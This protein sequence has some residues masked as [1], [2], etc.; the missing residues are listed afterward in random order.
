MCTQHSNFTSRGSEC[1]AHIHTCKDICRQ[2]AKT[3][4]YS[5]VL[6]RHTKRKLAQKPTAKYKRTENVCVNMHW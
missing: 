2:K 4:Q 6:H 3:R 1:D 5:S